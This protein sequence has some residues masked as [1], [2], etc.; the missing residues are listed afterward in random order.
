M[1]EHSSIMLQADSNKIVSRVYGYMLYEFENESAVFVDSLM[2]YRSRLNSNI[3]NRHNR[4]RTIG[5][6]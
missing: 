6:K 1:D 5:T 2:L 3:Y 4:Q